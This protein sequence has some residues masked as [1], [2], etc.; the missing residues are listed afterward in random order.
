MSQSQPPPSD[1]QAARDKTRDALARAFVDF[2]ASRTG[3]QGYI[4]AA[5]FGV[6]VIEAVVSLP[7]PASSVPPL[8]ARVIDACG[9]GVAV[10]RSRLQVAPALRL[11]PPLGEEPRG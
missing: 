8:L 10:I 9:E 7:V 3:A 1:M 11:A 5:M 2:V 6:G 4:D